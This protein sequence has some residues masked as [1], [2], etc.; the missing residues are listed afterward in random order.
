MMKQHVI[1]AYLAELAHDNLISFTKG[2]EALKTNSGG[3]ILGDFALRSPNLAG[4]L[5]D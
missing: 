2:A 1:S 4:I 3:L 5:R